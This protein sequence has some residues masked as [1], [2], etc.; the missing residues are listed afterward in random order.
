MYRFKKLYIYFKI[1]SCKVETASIMYEEGDNEN[2]SRL[3]LNKPKIVEIVYH[4]G[5]EKDLCI[6]AVIGI[7]RM[8]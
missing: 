7:K 6:Y 8:L 4:S 1:F 3:N 2:Q 5:F